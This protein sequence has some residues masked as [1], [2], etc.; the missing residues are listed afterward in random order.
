MSSLTPEAVVLEV[1]KD[2]AIEKEAVIKK[3]MKRNKTRD[4]ELSIS[5]EITAA[6][7]VKS[8]YVFR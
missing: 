4:I 8:L 3:G 1:C 7:H 5:P 6:L 2:F